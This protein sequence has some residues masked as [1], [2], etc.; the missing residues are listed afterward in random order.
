[1]IGAVVQRVREEVWAGC[2]DLVIM[3]RGAWEGRQG[4]TG[5][6]MRCANRAVKMGIE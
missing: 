6:R 1:M 2:V 5:F 4:D 3:L